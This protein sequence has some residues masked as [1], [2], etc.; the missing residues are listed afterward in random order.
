M[1]AKQGHYAHAA[2]VATYP[3]P[4][5]TLDRIGELRRHDLPALLAAAKTWEH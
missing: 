3:K 1:F 4:D 5:I 2:D